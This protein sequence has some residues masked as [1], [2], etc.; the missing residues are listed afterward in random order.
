MGLGSS[1]GLG[2]ILRPRVDMSSTVSARFAGTEIIFQFLVEQD[3]LLD[4]F[5]RRMKAVTTDQCG[6]KRF[7]L[8]KPMSRGAAISGWVQSDIP[9]CLPCS[10]F[11]SFNLLAMANDTLPTRGTS[12]NFEARFSV[13]FPL[14]L[15]ELHLITPRSPKFKKVRRVSLIKLE[16][17][18]SHERHER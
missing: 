13:L 3:Q 18:S 17:A 6:N 1:E 11:S 7:I 8:A 15:D 16:A 10:N 12:G 14:N 4:S 9:R 5:F 2:R